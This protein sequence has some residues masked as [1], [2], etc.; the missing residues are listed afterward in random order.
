MNEQITKD[1]LIQFGRMLVNEISIM[2]KGDYNREKDT[3]DPEWLKSR[4]ARKLL[5][6][7]AGSLQ[8]LRITGKVRY[9]KVMGSYYYNKADL[10]G[11]F[12]DVSSKDS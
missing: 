7:S 2:V 1:D 9:K 10:L 5:D 11:L 12:N 8:N 6:I 4:G 3:S